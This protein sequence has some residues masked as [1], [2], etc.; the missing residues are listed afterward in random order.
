MDFL[1][2]V[3]HPTTTSH[4]LEQ[5]LVILFA[6]VLQVTL[7]ALKACLA[8]ESLLLTCTSEAL[9]CEVHRIRRLNWWFDDHRL[10]A[11]VNLNNI[12]ASWRCA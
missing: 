5:L 2:P 7:L 11:D 8:Y 12:D 10:L 1:V 4:H 3:D 6:N 9:D